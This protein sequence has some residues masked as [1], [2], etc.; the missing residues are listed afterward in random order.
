MESPFWKVGYRVLPAATD[1]RGSGGEAYWENGSTTPVLDIEF[2]RGT[3]GR[4]VRE[5]LRDPPIANASSPDHARP[6]LGWYEYVR[7]DLGRLRQLLYH[8]HPGVD[9]KWLTDDDVLS[10]WVEID[11][12][13]SG[14]Q[15]REATIFYSGGGSVPV[16]FEYDTAGRMIGG[17]RPDVWPSSFSVTS[18]VCERPPERLFVLLL[19]ANGGPWHPFNLGGR[20]RPGV[21]PAG[22]R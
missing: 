21:R 20:S 10:N 4:T 22:P 15:P 8:S 1:A 7:D 17:S 11:Y 12:G 13:L 6:I 9:G 19:S 2:Q 14:D 18:D 16:R 3:D 5:I